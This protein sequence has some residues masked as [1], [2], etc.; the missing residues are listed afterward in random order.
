MTA[1]DRNQSPDGPIDRGAYM[2]E[3]VYQRIRDMIV[4]GRLGPGDRLVETALASHLGVSRTPVRE[5]IRR[6]VQERWVVLQDTGGVTVRELSARDLVDA[7]TARA[8]L[9]S[10]ATRLAA[11]N[12]TAQE[13]AELRKLT[14]QEAEA[15]KQADLVLLSK[16]NGMF[17]DGVARLSRNQP[18]LDALSGLAIHT[19]Y[20]KRAI[21]RAAEDPEWHTQYLEYVQHRNADHVTILN[22]IAQGDCDAAEEWMRQHVLE[23]ADNLVKLLKLN[24]DDGSELELSHIQLSQR[25]METSAV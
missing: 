18:L 13:I 1:A 7:Y 10:M 4:D 15:T 21:L 17:H 19:I 16:V 9:E 8:A 14:E 5:A 25:P 11:R 12:A 23:N 20:F 6:L 3:R 22:L 2:H 24:S